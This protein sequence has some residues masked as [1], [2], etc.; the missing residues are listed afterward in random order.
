MNVSENEVLETKTVNLE[1]NKKIIKNSTGK[2]RSNRD[3]E[4]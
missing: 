3:M 4:G 2:I 1:K